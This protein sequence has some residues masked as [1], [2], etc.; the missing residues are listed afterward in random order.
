[1]SIDTKAKKKDNKK[2]SGYYVDDVVA[3]SLIAL[4]L[5]IVTVTTF[6]AINL[7]LG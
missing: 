5:F 4:T 2:K 1:M 3:W 7:I 6:I